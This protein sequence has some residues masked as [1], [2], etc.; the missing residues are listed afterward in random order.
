MKLSKR[1]GIVY[2]ISLIASVVICICFYIGFKSGADEGERLRASEISTGAAHTFERLLVKNREEI[3][4]YK[5]IVENNYTEDNE[6]KKIETKGELNKTIFLVNTKNSNMMKISDDSEKINNNV[7]NSIKDVI[8]RDLGSKSGITK[9]GNEAFL[10]AYTPIDIGNYNYLVSV[11]KFDNKVKEYIGKSTDSEINIY[12]EKPLLKREVYK[13]KDKE[14]EHLFLEEDSKIYSFIEVNELGN[15]NK[16]YIEVV[17]TK[18]VQKTITKN[19][20]LFMVL[21]MIVTIIINMCLYIFIQKTVIKRVVGLSKK[22]TNVDIRKLDLE[23]LNEDKYK[24]EISNLTNVIKNLLKSSNHTN[25]E[26]KAYSEEMKYLANFDELT[27]VYNR[28][29]LT[30]CIDDLIRCNEEFSFY[31]IDLDNFKKV[32]D[33]V[34]HDYGDRLLLEV[35]NDLIKIS[36]KDIKIGRFGGDEFALIRIGK[37]SE[38]EV[39]KFAELVIKQI[40]KIYEF[41]KF[42]FKLNISMGIA[43]Y[44]FNGRDVQTIIKNADIAMYNSK[45][46]EGNKFTIFKKTL[47][48][49][50]LMEEKLNNAIKEKKLINYYQPIYSVETKEITGVEALVRWKEE[51]EIIFPDK[52]IP[53]AKR[54][55]VIIDIDKNVFENACIFSHEYSALYGTVID[56]SVNISYGLLTRPDFVDFVVEIVEKYKIPKNNIKLEIT[57]DEILEDIN[58]VID[59]LKK[60]RLKGFLISLDDFGVGYSSFNYVKNLPLD[61][62]KI[63]R[64]LILNIQEDKKTLAIIDTLIDLAQILELK[65]TCE[66]IENEIQLNLLKDLKCDNLQGYFFSKPIPK[67]DVLNYIEKF[68]KSSH[69]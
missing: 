64:S 8:N 32:N 31:F 30:E 55:G 68:N 46:I 33:T 35:A 52:F 41:K 43:I 13:T 60:L 26:L 5:K 53:I 67:E 4:L 47:L 36:S 15:E 19:F 48:E 59:I 38:E 17:V 12:L 51:N 56:I 63:D 7:I 27:S 49:D 62:I 65:V 40:S 10:L 57:E 34:G 11:T 50:Y 66:G 6:D 14:R 25:K 20:G 18:E 58:Y 21:L 22:L 45:L 61:V 42:Y 1:I 54:N 28:R 44:P 2:A 37:L 69:I 29:K 23:G 16:I 24:D 39:E 9:F 3:N